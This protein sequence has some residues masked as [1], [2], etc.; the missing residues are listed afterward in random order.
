MKLKTGAT[1]K[2]F[3]YFGELWSG[4][5]LVDDQHNYCKICL[6]GVMK[7]HKIDPTEE[8]DVKARGIKLD[9]FSR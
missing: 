4:N 7:S 6:L 8:I 3:E 5:M 1:S 9:V 2:A